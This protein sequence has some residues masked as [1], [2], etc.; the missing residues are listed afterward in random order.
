MPKLS[1]GNQNST[2]LELAALQAKQGFFC[3]LKWEYFANRPDLACRRKLQDIEHLLPRTEQR[4]DHSLL[5]HKG[6]WSNLGKRAEYDYTSNFD[7]A[8]SL[9][10]Q[11]TRRRE[12][13]SGIHP[14]T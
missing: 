5:L 13:D 9:P 7:R 2:R 4:A 3:L 8:D 11:R 1:L 10:H 6:Q 14:S 12:D